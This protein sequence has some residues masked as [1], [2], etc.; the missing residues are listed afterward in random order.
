MHYPESTSANT[1][2][3]C[4]HTQK[5]TKHHAMHSLVIEISTEGK[6]YQKH[7]Y[8]GCFIENNSFDL[9]IFVK[10]W[11]IFCKFYKNCPQFG[12]FL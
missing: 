7:I 9:Y 8:T 11:T 10:L 3:Y 4:M 1:A 6:F 2:L 12:Q 5:V